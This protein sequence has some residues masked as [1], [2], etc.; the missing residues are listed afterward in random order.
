MTAP[1]PLAGVRKSRSLQW[2]K[3]ASPFSAQYIE[4][5]GRI[6]HLAHCLLGGRDPALAFLNTCHAGLGARPL[7]LAGVSPAGYLAVQGEIER[8]ALSLRPME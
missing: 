5:Q 1:E 3:K 2:R 6:A 7:D 8:L 4:R